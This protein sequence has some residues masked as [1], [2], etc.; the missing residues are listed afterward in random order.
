MIDSIFSKAPSNLAQNFG[1]RVA[2]AMGHGMRLH[3]ESEE[4]RD[5]WFLALLGVQS[6]QD[7]LSAEQAQSINKALEPFG[8]AA[9]AE[10]AKR[11]LGKFVR[12]AWEAANEAQLAGAG[13]YFNEILEMVDAKNIVATIEKLLPQAKKRLWEELPPPAGVPEAYAQIWATPAKPAPATP[14]RGDR[15]DRADLGQRQAPPTPMTPPAPNLS[16]AEIAR[17][18]L[19]SWGWRGADLDAILGGPHGPGRS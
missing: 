6:Y 14:V 1:S 3:K 4:L 15:F 2:L 9:L 5:L 18:V 17:T 11:Y 13:V 19:A 7:Q 12:A 16:R 10:Q 8:L